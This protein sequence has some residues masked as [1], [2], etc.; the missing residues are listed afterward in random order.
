MDRLVPGFEPRL[1]L[2]FV[3]SPHASGD[4]LW[5]AALGSEV[6]RSLLPRRQRL[7]ST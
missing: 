4:N 6:P 7:C 2:G 5:R 3:A 1:R